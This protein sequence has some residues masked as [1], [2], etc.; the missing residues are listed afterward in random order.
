MLMVGGRRIGL[1]VPGVILALI[2]FGIAG[3]AVA[4]SARFYAGSFEMEVL[5]ISAIPYVL[6]LA[7][8]R[9]L[10]A[11]VITGIAL[12]GST[13]WTYVSFGLVPGSSRD[14]VEVLWILLG[15]ALNLLVVA[16]G[17]LVDRVFLAQT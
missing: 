11:T 2:G 9:S 3:W 5:V 13:L 15:L 7:W 17:A 12:V 14:G 16:I 6:Y 8:I 10:K 1:R 4:R